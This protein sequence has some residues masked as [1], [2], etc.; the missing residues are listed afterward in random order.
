[1]CDKQGQYWFWR[2]ITLNFGVMVA[3]CLDE[4]LHFIN[5]LCSLPHIA[6]GGQTPMDTLIHVWMQAQCKPQYGAAGSLAQLFPQLAGDGDQSITVAPGGPRSQAPGR[7]W[8]SSPPASLPVLPW[9][10]R[11]LISV[12][13]LV[14]SD[15]LFNSNV[16]RYCCIVKIMPSNL[17]SLPENNIF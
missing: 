1:M 11:K 17:S 10:N 14:Q 7:L 9:E 15:G 5:R 12:I 3:E 8:S 13:F 4:K 6:Q 16:P 2:C